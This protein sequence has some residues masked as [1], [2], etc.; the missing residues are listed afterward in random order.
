MCE[1]KIEK[2]LKY[3]PSLLT[4]KKLILLETCKM[5]IRKIGYINVNRLELNPWQKLK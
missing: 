2:E 5:L 1:G 3:I 4:T